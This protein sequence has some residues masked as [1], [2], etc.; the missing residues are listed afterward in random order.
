MKPRI[1]RL[2][3]RL[4]IGGPAIQALSLTRAFA[5][6]YDT[7]LG[8]GYA[9]P[10][11]GEMTDPAV[12][13]VH[14]PL[15]RP[16]SP[17]R[18]MAAYR[19]VARLIRSERPEILHTHM[20]KAGAIGRLA[21]NRHA[22]ETRTV[23]TFHGHVLEGYFRPAVSEAFLRVERRLAKHTD[24]LVAVS[25]EVRDD[26]LNLGIGNAQKWRV[27]P[28]GFDLSSFLEVDAPRGEL[29]RTFGIGPDELV[30][31]A[32]GRFAPVKDHALLLEATARL[33]GVHLILLGDGETRPG[34]VARAGDRDLVGRVHFAGWKRNVADALSDMDVVAVTSLNEGTPVSLI[35]A[36]ASG[37]SVVATRVGGVASVVDHGETGLLVDSRDPGDISDALE[38]LLRDADLRRRFGIEGRSR[39]V[40]RFG[41]ERLVRD[42]GTL[43]TELLS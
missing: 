35:E 29:R 31:G 38:T 21:A 7:T 22:P 33:D 14:L 4:N 9:A 25:Q 17:L 37:R 32:L 40:D 13:V 41:F 5:L 34:L 16:I 39:M 27:I 2:I 28:L 6:E 18:D 26:L 8:A 19:A 36:L 3:T 30:I 42:I 11:E 23:H 15:T 24:A 43:Y 10:N 12:D 1:L 20:A